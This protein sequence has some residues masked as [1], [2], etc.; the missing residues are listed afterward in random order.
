[1]PGGALSR[2][3]DCGRLS[4]RLDAEAGP[5][6]PGH[7]GL[8]SGAAP[9]DGRLQEGTAMRPPTVRALGRTSRRAAGITADV[10]QPR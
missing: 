1:M 5:G 9:R 8:L 3:S 4:R 10:P 6:E 7:R 2:T